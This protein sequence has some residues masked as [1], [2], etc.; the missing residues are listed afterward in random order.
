MEQKIQ[1]KK[2][3][4]FNL[5]N[6]ACQEAFK[7]ATTSTINNK[8]LSSVFEEDGNIDELTGKFLKRLNKTLHNSAL[9]KLR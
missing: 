7:N 9:E 5:K 1:R 2:A 6:A 8:F 4:I 3:E